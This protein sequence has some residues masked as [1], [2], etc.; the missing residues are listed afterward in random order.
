MKSPTSQMIRHLRGPETTDVTIV[1]IALD[2]LTQAGCPTR[3]VNFP[4]GRKEQGAAH[5]VMRALLRR[6]PLLKR[7]DVAVFR[8]DVIF[9]SLR[10]TIDCLDVFH[11]A[12]LSIQRRE[13]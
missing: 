3:R 12:F 2:R 1:Q 8:G 7:E 10:F 4:S 6:W 13:R 11:I 9:N 5:R